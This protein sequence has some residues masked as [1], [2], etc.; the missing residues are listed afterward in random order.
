M[1]LQN[2]RIELIPAKPFSHRL[3][4]QKIP[5]RLLDPSRIFFHS[6]SKPSQQGL[7]AACA[8]RTIIAPSL[9]RESAPVVRSPRRSIPP[10]L[11]DSYLARRWPPINIVVKHQHQHLTSL[12]KKHFI[13]FPFHYA[14][15]IMKSQT[16]RQFLG[17]R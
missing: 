3:S 2:Q 16:A 11:I 10:Y 7:K 13:S 4:K 14:L 15:C 9:W 12:S 8:P 5:T 6:G 1:P 17:P